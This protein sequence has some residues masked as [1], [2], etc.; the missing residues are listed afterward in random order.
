VSTLYEPPTQLLSCVSLAFFSCVSL[1]LFS[2]V[3]LLSCYH[4][5]IPQ[6]ECLASSRTSKQMTFR[7]TR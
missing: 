6:I 7:V 1:E 4:V 5:R 2:C 3:L